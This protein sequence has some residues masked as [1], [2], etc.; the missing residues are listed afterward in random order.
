MC[1]WNPLAA[2]RNKYVKYKEGIESLR[3]LPSEGIEMKVLPIKKNFKMIVQSKKSWTPTHLLGSDL[4]RYLLGYLSF[5]DPQLCTKVLN[6][7][8]DKCTGC[9][10]KITTLHFAWYFWNQR[11]ELQTVFTYWKLKS[12]RKFWIQNHICAI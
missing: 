3:Y 5:F 4:T 2:N 9:P 10:K 12:M 8:S 11:T 7:H 1:F 6:L